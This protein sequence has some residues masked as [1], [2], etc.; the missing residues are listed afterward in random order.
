MGE[1][2]LRVVRHGIRPP[3]RPPVSHPKI[4]PPHSRPR[5]HLKAK[6]STRPPFG[7]SYD[8]KFLDRRDWSWLHPRLLRGA[9][10]RRCVG[11]EWSRIDGR[12]RTV[13]GFRSYRDHDDGRGRRSRDGCR[14]FRGERRIGR[15]RDRRARGNGR[16]RRNVGAG[17][18]RRT[19]WSWQHSWSGSWRST[20]WCWRP[21]GH[22]KRSRWGRP[23][24][25]PML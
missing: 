9:P 4:G 14:G 18:N 5:P 21:G 24:I 16:R 22:R 11:W 23:R 15:N 2:S 13:G 25:R 7:I 10:D 12:R 20:W 17:G 6:G 1:G 19:C 8:K 3:D